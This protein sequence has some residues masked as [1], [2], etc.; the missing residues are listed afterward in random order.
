MKLQLA[1]IAFFQLSSMSFLLIPAARELSLVVNLFIA[2]I[3]K[4]IDFRAS[5][6]L[7][8]LSKLEVKRKSYYETLARQTRF[9]VDHQ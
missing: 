4:F 1:S 8:K 9:V 5:V 7:S 2:W 3:W 6:K